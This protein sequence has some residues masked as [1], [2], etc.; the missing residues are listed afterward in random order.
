MM[1][2]WITYTRFKLICQAF[3]YKAY[4]SELDNLLIQIRFTPRGK[5]KASSLDEVQR[6]R[7]KPK[8]LNL[9]SVSCIEV[10]HWKYQG[11]RLKEIYSNIDKIWPCTSSSREAV[12]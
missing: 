10:T 11:K 12:T 3:S 2:A 4:F 1:H 9:D 7:G 6:N 8:P 5:R